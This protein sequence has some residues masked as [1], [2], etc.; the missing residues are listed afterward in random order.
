VTLAPWLFTGTH[1]KEVPFGTIAMKFWISSTHAIVAC[2]ELLQ[3]ERA[4]AILDGIRISQK[5]WGLD[6]EI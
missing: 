2:G 3:M 6:Y 4:R 5:V 1:K